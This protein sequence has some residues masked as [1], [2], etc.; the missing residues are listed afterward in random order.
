[1]T[2]FPWDLAT[3]TLYPE[4][5]LQVYDHRLQTCIVT[6]PL[7]RIGLYSTLP[8]TTQVNFADLQLY[9]HRRCLGLPSGTAM[10]DC[11]IWKCYV[12]PPVRMDQHSSSVLQ[13]SSLYSLAQ[14][15]FISLTIYSIGSASTLGDT[16]YPSGGSHNVQH[17]EYVQ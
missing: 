13:W 2:L 3:W 11:H 16:A 6:T 15:L 1:M 8:I 17:H 5:V 10:F 14:S 12:I 4:I 7:F 9:C